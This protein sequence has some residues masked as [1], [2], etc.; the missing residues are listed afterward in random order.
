MIVSIQEALESI[1]KEIPEEMLTKKIKGIE[2]LIRDE[3]NNKFQER[4]VRFYAA[5][6]DILL[7]GSSPFLKIGNNIEISESVNEGLYTITEVTEDYLK[8]DA[9]LYPLSRNM[10][11]KI[12]YPESVRQ[13]V[14]NLLKWDYTMRDKV[15]IKNESLSRYS[16][17]YYDM[18]TD[19]SLGGYP[20]SLMGFLEPYYNPRY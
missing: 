13:G 14:L 18:D 17:S 6:S 12:V 9:P 7:L 3:T 5:S 16:V 8:L 4:R 10:I 15:G 20:S 11:T 19:N 2:Q 1:G